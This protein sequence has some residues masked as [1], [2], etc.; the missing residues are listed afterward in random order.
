[1]VI[2]TPDLLMNQTNW[3]GPARLAS[4]LVKINYLR[5]S[6]QNTVPSL[7]KLKCHYVVEAE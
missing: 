4:R 5:N 6:L 1:M 2:R 3:G 7:G